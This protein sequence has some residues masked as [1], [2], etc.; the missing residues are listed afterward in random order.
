MVVASGGDHFTGYANMYTSFSERGGP[1]IF[2][3]KDLS[4]SNAI[5][6]MTN[7]KPQFEVLVAHFE[8][9]RLFDFDALP[10]IRL[11]SI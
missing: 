2:L 10:L 5:T 1:I 9:R 6:A 7:L 8:F 3:S 4:D 11:A